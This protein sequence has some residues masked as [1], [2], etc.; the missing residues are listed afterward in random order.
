MRRRLA[1][2]MGDGSRFFGS[3][4]HAGAVCVPRADQPPPYR[5]NC[6]GRQDTAS[7]SL[8]DYRRGSVSRLDKPG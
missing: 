2:R 7:P 6:P 5:F 1:P 3:S 8:A 4:V